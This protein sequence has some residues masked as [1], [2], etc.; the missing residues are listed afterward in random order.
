M[1]K[2]GTLEV[3]CYHLCYPALQT[4]FQSFELVF[5]D[6]SFPQKCEANHANLITT[7][8]S[9]ASLVPVE[10]PQRIWGEPFRHRRMREFP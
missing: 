4:G 7:K 8:L 6:E 2:D 9:V 1:S 10:G 5:V 3:F